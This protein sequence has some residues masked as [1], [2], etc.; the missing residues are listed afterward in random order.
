MSKE[1]SAYPPSSIKAIDDSSD[2]PEI[3][4]KCFLDV[5]IEDI[6]KQSFGMTELDD[7]LYSNYPTAARLIY[8]NK[9]PSDYAKMILRFPSIN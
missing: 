9:E 3:L 5:D 7:E 6:V 1:G 4:E 2:V 8:S